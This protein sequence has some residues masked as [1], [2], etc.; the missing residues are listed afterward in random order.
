M[1]LGVTVRAPAVKVLDRLQGLGLRGVATRNMARVANPR[2]ANLEKLRIAAAVRIVAIGAVLHHRRMFPQERPPALGMAGEA[3]LVHTRLQQ[4]GWIRASVR[5]I[6]TGAGYFS[7]SIRHMRGALK[8][9][10]AH[11]M[12]LEA[13]LRLRLLRPDM[14]G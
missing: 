7:L 10:P 11:L 8:L 1:D 12:T 14:F 6:T 3:V 4:L 9:C 13:Q 5:V 2:H